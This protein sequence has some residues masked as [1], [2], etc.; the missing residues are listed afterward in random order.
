MSYYVA[1]YD[2][3]AIYAWWE[4]RSST[5]RGYESIVRYDKEGLAVFLA[6]VEA[7]AAVHLASNTPATFFIVAKLL[8]YVGVELRSILDHPNF[9]LQCHSYTHK[10]LIGIAGDEVV[11]QRE[12]VDAKKRIE[13]IFGR[14]VIGLTAPGGYTYGFTGQQRILELM[15]AS[16]YRYVRSVGAGPEG[17]VPAPLN[18]PFW[19]EADGFSKILEIPSHAW[20]DNILTGQP[21]IVHWPPVLPWAYPSTMPTDAQG[22]YEA[23]APGIDY[24]ADNDLFTYIPIFHPWSI[25]RIDKQASQIK[26]LLDKAQQRMEVVSC[27]QIYQRVCKDRSLAMGTPP[28]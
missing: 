4:C 18:Q 10:D 7:V 16:G 26:Y 12:F 3:E 20:H 28:A 9:D 27:I 24:V 21:G 17:T 22:V 14:A 13:D 1:A 5:A 2:T 15:Q 25:Y 19:Y 23:Y 6:G 11:L 8:D